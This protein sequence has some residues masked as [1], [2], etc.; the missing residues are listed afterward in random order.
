MRL[1]NIMK[2]YLNFVPKKIVDKGQNRGPSLSPR[3]NEP[4]NK[5]LH[6]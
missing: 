6:K 1:K 4:F 3:N 2:G 5:N